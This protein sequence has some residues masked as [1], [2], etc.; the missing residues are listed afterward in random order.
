M[1]AYVVPITSSDEGKTNIHRDLHAILATMPETNKLFDL[2][3]FHARIGKVHTGH[4]ATPLADIAAPTVVKALLSPRLAIFG[5]SSTITTDRGAQCESNLFQSLLPFFVQ[6]V[7]QT[8]AY[9]PAANGMA[10]RFHRQLKGSQRPVDDPKNWADHLPLLLLGI[11]SVLQPN[12]DCSTANLV[13]CATFR[14]PDEVI[15]SN[16][17][18]AVEDPTNLLDRPR[19]FVKTL[20]PILPRSSHS[21]P[22]VEKDLAT[23]SHVYL[24]YGRVRSL[25]PE[26]TPLADIAAPTVVNALVSP[27]LA[28]FGTSSTIS[29]DRGAQCESNL[30][31]SL[32]PFF[33]QNVIQTTAYHPAANGKAVRFHRQLKG[34]QRP[35]DDPENW[36]DHLSLLLLGIHSVLQPNLDCSTANLVICATFRLLG[37]MI[38][39]NP[40]GAVEDPTN[41]LD[42]PRQ[43]V[44]TLSPILPRSSHS[45]SYVEKDLATCSHVYLRYGRVRSLW[46]SP[47]TAHP[48]SSLEGQR[49]SAF[50]V[51]IMGWFHYATASAR[52]P[53]C[54]TL[55]RTGH[56]SPVGEERKILGRGNDRVARETIEAWHTETTSINR[57]VALPTAYQ[58]LRTQL[59]EL[60]GKREVRPDVDLNTKEPTTDLHVATPQIGPDEGAVINTVASTT[61]PADGEKRGQKDAIK[62]SNPVRQLSFSRKTTRQRS[63]GEKPKFWLAITYVKNVSEATARILNPFGIGVAHKPESTI[64]Q[65]IMRPKDPLPATEQSAVVH[66]IPCQNCNARYVGETGK[67]LCTRLHEHQLAVN[68]EDKLSLVYGHMQQEKHSFAF[69]EAS[70]LSRAHD[71][72]AR[73]V[74]ESWSSVGTINRAIDLHP[75]YQALRTRLQSVQTGPTVLASESRLL[76]QLSPSQQ[77][78]GASRRSHDERETSP[79]RRAQTAER[80]SHMQWQLIGPSDYEVRA[81]GHTGL[82]A[83]TTAG[84]GAEVTGA[85]HWPPAEEPK[86]IPSQK[87]VQNVPATAVLELIDLCLE[88]N[89]SFNQQYYQQLKGA[90]MGS[91][92]S[93]FLAEVTMQK[94]ET[95]ALPLI[96][97][98][99]WLRY[100]DDTFVI[101][102]KDQ[103]EALHNN[104]NS[105]IPGITFTLEKEVDSK[106]PFLDVLVQRKTDGTLPCD[107]VYC[108]QTGKRASTRIHEHQLAV[109]RRDHLSQVAMHTLDTEHTFAWEKTRIVAVCPS[110]KGREFLEAMHSD[111]SCIN[112]HIEL[113]AAYSNLKERWKRRGPIRTD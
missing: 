73:L 68:R 57:C 4:E 20:S 77:G 28:I 41:L 32:L 64:R 90:P 11:H 21:L 65:Q 38:L 108:G 39:S 79:H 35:V 23:C 53:F 86:P 97:P 51:L 14:L 15:L 103:L 72:M 106:L 66:S 102:K 43:F 13:I 98:K 110:K 96:K 83:I 88:T 54:D 37:E 67:R 26:A 47:M 69:G 29:T 52:P 81:H 33:V 1:S 16:T 56:P 70:V 76:Q 101:V 27:W 5:T 58:A 94:L 75:A 91:P 40:R 84:Q 78:E 46:I 85:R 42:R 111:E 10:V 59:N 89:F 104:I 80:D 48:A 62:T 7:I 109:K 30:F 3:N 44:K 24:R 93:G 74:L 12:L 17:H 107:A 61:T 82:A 55:R 19:Q 100:V 2:A 99:L 45:L 36:T 92:I 22:Y 8:T 113:D 60:K 31:Q 6:N 18:G 105:T 25:W 63:D 112:R 9:H 71:K 95:T 49:R 50:N 87:A 34:S